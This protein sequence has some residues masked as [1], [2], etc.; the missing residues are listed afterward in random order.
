[1]RAPRS[2]VVV[3]VV[4]WLGA[5]RGDD[6]TGGGD[7]D[8][9]VDAAVPACATMPRTTAPETFVGPTGL[10]DRLTALIDGAQSSLDI[11]MYLWTVK[12]LA[13]RVVAAKQRG[14]AVRV[15]IDEDEETQDDIDY[16]KGLGIT[17]KA[18]SSS[19]FLLH[20]KLIIAD[21]VAFIGSE[22]MSVTSLT[23]NREV[24]ALVDEPGAAD[25]IKAQFE[26]DWNATQP[27]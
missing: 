12:P 9:R 23:R 24:G 15:I 13:D 8:D 18:P 4:A 27:R 2:F 10:Q 7:D 26:S 22:N 11:H 5:C 20:S 17:V 6:G 14:V 19:Q 25:P 1:M 3:L 16:L 21:G